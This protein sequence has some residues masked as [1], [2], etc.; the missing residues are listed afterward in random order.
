MLLPAEMTFGRT[1]ANAVEWIVD[2]FHFITGHTGKK[3]AETYNPKTHRLINDHGEKL[4]TSTMAETVNSW[5]SKLAPWLKNVDM[6]TF[7]FI[8]LSYVEIRNDHT[9]AKMAAKS[10]S[11]VSA[12]IGEL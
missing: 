4:F 9:K 12:G 2:R 10:T 7:K 5:L 8:L 3:C 6:L 11:V 1:L